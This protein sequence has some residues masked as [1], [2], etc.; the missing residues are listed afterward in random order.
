MIAGMI[1]DKNDDDGDENVGGDDE[2]DNDDVDNDDVN[3]DDDGDVYSNDIVHITC[4]KSTLLTF[5]W[6][7]CCCSFQNLFAN[8]HT[9][10]L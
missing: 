7:N 8:C 5:Q 4:L 9:K 10:H 3:D 6:T 1:T 2:H